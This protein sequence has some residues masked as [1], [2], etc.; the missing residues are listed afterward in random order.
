M[1]PGAVV[2]LGQVEHRLAEMGAELDGRDGAIGHQPRHHLPRCAQRADEILEGHL[3]W[4]VSGLGF[5]VSGFGFRVWGL[6]FRVSGF[7][8][9][10]PGV[11]FRGSGFGFRVWG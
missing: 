9:Q 10:V 2:A 8:F 11:G 7:G 4:R 6:G 1:V 5:R 3:R